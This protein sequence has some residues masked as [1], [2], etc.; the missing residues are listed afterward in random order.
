MVLELDE[1]NC[2]VQGRH[3]WF[4]ANRYDKYLGRA[5]YRYGE[6]GEMEQVFLQSFLAR[7]DWVIEVGA[8][9]GAHT[10]GLAKFV[11]GN[12]KVIA[13]EPQPPIFHTLCGNIAL[14]SMHNI[15]IYNCGCGSAEGTMTV[16]KMR[17]AN[18]ELHNSGAVSLNADTE[19][20]IRVPVHSLDTLL[21]NPAKL[22]LIKIDVEGM[23]EDVLRGAGTLIQMHR[24]ILYVENDRPE[25][26]ESLIEHLMEL[27]YRLWWHTPKL[28]SADNYFREVDNEY[29]DIVSVNM[30]CCPEER[31]P[32]LA[33]Y[34][35]DFRE[36]LNST[37]H[38]L[39]TGM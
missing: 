24:P 35:R 19:S 39:I 17:Y 25:K 22:K 26:S 27:G 30:L 16:P 11:G 32:Q 9:I 2:L 6:Y 14:N 29:G 7:G 1:I 8:N 15:E 21:P 33:Q 36:V 4:I 28:F 13:I 38:P 37:E 31:V 10:V 5:L 23:E 3:G 20:G 12:G 18:A 34:S